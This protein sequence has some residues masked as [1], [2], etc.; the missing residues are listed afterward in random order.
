[1]LKKYTYQYIECEGKSERQLIENIIWADDISISRLRESKNWMID[2]TYHH[3]KDFYQ[4]LIIYYKD[5]ITKEKYPSF[6]V[7]MNNKL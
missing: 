1:M 2:A 7:L 5:K 4:L 6:F 3:P